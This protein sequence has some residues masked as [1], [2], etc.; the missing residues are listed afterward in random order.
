[1]ATGNGNEHAVVVD[2]DG[3]CDHLAWRLFDVGESTLSRWKYKELLKSP[4]DELKTNV[5]LVA[6]GP[7]GY[8]FVGCKEGLC[9]YRETSP[10][11][12]GIAIVDDGEIHLGYAVHALGIS[13]NGLKLFVLS[14]SKLFFYNVSSLVK[15]AVSHEAFADIGSAV[16]QAAWVTDSTL[17]A[18]SIHGD[19]YRVST[20]GGSPEKVEQGV[21]SAD[22]NP[23]INKGAFG[24]MDG[25]IHIVGS[26]LESQQNIENE[27]DGK[28]FFVKVLEDSYLAAVHPKIESDD[29]DSDDEDS[30]D[31]DSEDEDDEDEDSEEDGRKNYI[32]KF[33]CNRQSLFN[34]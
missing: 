23:K 17:L 16:R 13:R 12:T 10:D 6:A 20:N 24:M 5:S 19:A 1:M 27:G 11:Q 33:L 28:C 21:Y 22:F 34:F 29:E 30:E 9:V 31:E 15:N 8:I 25:S 4:H 18:I 32:N 14:H 26:N 3:T 7:S 2:E